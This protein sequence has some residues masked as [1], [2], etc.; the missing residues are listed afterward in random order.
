M[1]LQGTG[2][3]K[4]WGKGKLHCLPKPTSGGFESKFK[5][6]CVY[7]ICE[8]KKKPKSEMAW[9]VFLLEKDSLFER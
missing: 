3:P 6:L 9:Q 4:T 2:F 7:Y 8:G 1:F 5:L